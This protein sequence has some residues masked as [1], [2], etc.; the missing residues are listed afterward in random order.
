MKNL[1]NSWMQKKDRDITLFNLL[2]L[3]RLVSKSSDKSDIEAF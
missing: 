1:G 3:K 2:A